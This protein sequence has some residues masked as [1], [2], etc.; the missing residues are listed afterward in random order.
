M[1]IQPKFVQ[2]VPEVS[3]KKIKVYIAYGKQTMKD[4]GKL[5]TKAF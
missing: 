5:M 4:G 2:I 1:T 3:E